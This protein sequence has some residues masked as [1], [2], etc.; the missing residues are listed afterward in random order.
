MIIYHNGQIGVG[1]NSVNA[2]AKFEV[3]GN[4]MSSGSSTILML[5]NTGGTPQS[6]WIGQDISGSND[7]IFYIYNQTTSTQAINIRKNNNVLIGTSTDNGFSL[8]VNGSIWGQKFRMNDT[9]GGYVTWEMENT[10]RWRMNYLA[11][12]SGYGAGALTTDASGN[13]TAS[14]DRTLKNVIKPIENVLENIKDFEPV[15]F[16]W[17][18]KTD[19]DKENVYM[20]T[21]AQSIQ[22]HYPDAVGKMADGTLTVQDR[23]VTAILVQAIKEL[24]EKVKTLENK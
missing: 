15:Y 21:I 18:E 12:L 4:I 6:W 3:S 2:Y 14:S 22:K 19:L 16:K 9:G 5:N 23:A 11:R 13:V 10:T 17:N 20:S 1:T 8:Q 7:G 24:T